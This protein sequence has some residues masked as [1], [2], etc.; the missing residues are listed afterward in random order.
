MF[1][2]LLCLGGSVLIG[3]VAAGRRAIQMRA[4][5]NADKANSWLRLAGWLSAF[6]A[7]VLAYALIGWPWKKVVVST[8]EEIVET[9]MVPEEEVVET[10][11]SVFG[12]NLWRSSS[13]VVHKNT[14]K[15][16]TKQVPTEHF[17]RRFSIWLLIMEI[18]IAAIAYWSELWICGLLW[19]RLPRRFVGE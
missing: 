2:L 12:I 8:L 16:I 4:C 14:K 18:P 1:R 13:E 5:G 11:R 9:V 6:S 3:L 17:Q 7:V 15:S 19:R 10:W